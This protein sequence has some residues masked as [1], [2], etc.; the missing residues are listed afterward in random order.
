M[1][2]FDDVNDITIFTPR[3]DK[4]LDGNKTTLT[5]TEELIRLWWRDPICQLWHIPLHLL[6]ITTEGNITQDA[7][8]ETGDT[9][10]PEPSGHDMIYNVY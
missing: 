8:R 7:S 2:K 6:G 5:S 4:N 3:E 10:A 1:S 9:K